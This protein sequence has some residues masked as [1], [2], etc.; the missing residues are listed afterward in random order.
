MG[1]V[2]NLRPSRIEVWSGTKSGDTRPTWFLS[3]ADGEGETVVHECASEARA[4]AAAAEW[5]MPVVVRR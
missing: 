3:F 2:V 4:I 1:T 5:K